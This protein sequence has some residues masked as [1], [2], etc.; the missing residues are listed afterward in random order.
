MTMIYADRGQTVAEEYFSVTLSPDGYETAWH[1]TQAEQ[2][3][4]AILTPTP[5]GAR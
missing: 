3:D 2:P 1:I 4:R 5:T